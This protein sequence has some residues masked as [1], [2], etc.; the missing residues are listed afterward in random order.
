MLLE[1]KNAVVYGGGGSIG[2]AV[3]RAFAREGA[4]VFLAGRNPGP[5]DG[6]AGEISAAGGTAEAAV[7]EATDERSVEGH[8][9]WVVEKAGSIDVTFNAIS[10][11]GDLQGI[12]LIDM[13]VEDFALPIS[14]GTTAHFLTARAAGRRMAERGSGVILTL[15]TPAP[16]LSGRDRRFHRTGGAGPACAAIV[17]L[18]K[19]LAGELGPRGVR[20]VCLMPDAIPEVWPGGFE[21]GTPEADEED[22]ADADA[23]R[24]LA[25]MNDGTLLGRL[26]RL[27]EV[28]NAAAFLASDRAGAMTGTVANLTC[29]SVVD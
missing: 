2:G 19:Q 13:T 27:E 6:V 24:A 18:T 23:R 4:R 7:V 28:A 25:Y 12:P 10:I 17:E 14:V 15:S 11:R 21:D 8:V 26:P 3:A 16:A 5:L 29:G 9:D 20:A 22:P 1:G